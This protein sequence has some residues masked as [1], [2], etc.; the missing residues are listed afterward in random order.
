ML[1]AYKRAIYKSMDDE[2]ETKRAAKNFK[3]KKWVEEFIEMFFILIFFTSL[4][5]TFYAAR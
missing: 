2:V 3:S 4:E 1:S 5:S